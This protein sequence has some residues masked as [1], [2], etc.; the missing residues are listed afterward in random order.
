MRGRPIAAGPALTGPAGARSL[1]TSY[2]ARIGGQ[3]LA[4]SNGVAL[5]SVAAIIR[6]DRANFHR[7]GLR[8]A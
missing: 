6:Q 5:G 8:A 1:V 2:R 3:D 7:L 4:N